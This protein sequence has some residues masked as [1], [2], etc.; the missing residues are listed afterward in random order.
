MRGTVGAAGARATNGIRMPGAPA[1]AGEASAYADQEKE[2]ATPRETSAC[3][4]GGRRVPQP[5]RRPRVERPRTPHH[6]RPVLARTKHEATAS[7]GTA[8]RAPS[9]ARAPAA[10]AAR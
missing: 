9:T 7:S 10:P 4:Q 5:A 6:P 1:P 2:A 8:T 3:R